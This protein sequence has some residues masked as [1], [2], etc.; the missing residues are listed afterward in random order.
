MKPSEL[1]A[2]SEAQLAEQLEQ[3]R[4]EYFKLRFQ[5]A[6]GGLNDTSKLRQAR[7]EIARIAT[8]LGELGRAA[9]SEMEEQQA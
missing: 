3:A 6:S 1:R 8:V 4:E 9:A 2:M 7:R 5:L